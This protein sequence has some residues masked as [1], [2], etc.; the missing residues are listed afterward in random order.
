MKRFFIAAIIFCSGPASAQIDS[1]I[2]EKVSNFLNI[3]FRRNSADSVID[4][5]A[6]PFYTNDLTSKKYRF[7]SKAQFRAKLVAAYSKPENKFQQYKIISIENN[8]CKDAPAQ[9][10]GKVIC[11]NVK[12]NFPSAGEGGS[13]ADI[14]CIIFIQRNYPYKIMG[15]KQIQ[16]V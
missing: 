2:K 7:F 4:L 11:V 10:A 16:R 15:V 1:T 3:N 13:G 5:C 6:F 9:F 8:S 12:I 14:D